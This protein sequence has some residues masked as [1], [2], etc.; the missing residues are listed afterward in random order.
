MPASDSLQFTTGRVQIG[1]AGQR[2][3]ESRCRSARGC[4]SCRRRR[5]REQAIDRVERLVERLCLEQS[6]ERA[7]G[8]LQREFRGKGVVGE[9]EA[10]HLEAAHLDAGKLAL[11][12]PGAVQRQHLVD[13]LQRRARDLVVGLCENRLHVGAANVEAQPAQR[14]T[15]PRA[16]RVDA[17]Q[18]LLGSNPPAAA[19]LE[20]LLE[21]ERQFLAVEKRRVFAR[22]ERDPFGAQGENRI[23]PFPRLRHAGFRRDDSLLRDDQLRVVRFGDAKRFVERESW[24]AEKVPE[25]TGH[26]Q[27][28]RQE[29]RCTHVS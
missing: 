2:L 16:R 23:G 3:A 5:W 6:E 11:L 14:I 12:V 20:F 17:M 26:L 25:R 4:H 18:R 22:R 13:L 9:P 28:P 27:T 15:R 19:R 7:A 21:A 10:L 8:V 29:R 24:R 1:P